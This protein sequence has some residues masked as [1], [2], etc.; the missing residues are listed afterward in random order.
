M[1][2]LQDPV[3]KEIE[4]LSKS[5]TQMA[6][7]LQERTGYIRDFATHVSHEFKTPL[8]SIQGAAELLEERGHTMSS[9]EKNKF[10]RNITNNCQRLKI[11]VGR[12]LELARADNLEATQETTSFNDILDIEGDKNNLIKWALWE[13]V[14]R[15]ST[16]GS[17]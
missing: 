2:P 6:N 15:R 5:F 4:L 17:F 1:V 11:L 7:S 8:T 16:P 12:L 14:S 10:F 9:E 3:I 13:R